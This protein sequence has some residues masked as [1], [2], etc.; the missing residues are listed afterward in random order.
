M[1]ER[2]SVECCKKTKISRIGHKQHSTRT[3][4]IIFVGYMNLVL[5]KFLSQNIHDNMNI[6]TTYSCDTG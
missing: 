5:L 1:E 3:Q 4:T 6:S 2:L